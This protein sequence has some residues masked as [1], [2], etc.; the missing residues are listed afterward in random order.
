VIRNDKLS[1]LTKDNDWI[2]ESG[3]IIQLIENKY[4]LEFKDHTKDVPS[5]QADTS[6]SP[7]ALAEPATPLTTAPAN[8]PI[9]DSKEPITDAK[10]TASPVAAVTETLDAPLLVVSGLATKRNKIDFHI[11]TEVDGTLQP[12]DNQSLQDAETEQ[13]AKRRKISDDTSD[14]EG[15][16]DTIMSEGKQEETDDTLVRAVRFYSYRSL[17]ILDRRRRGRACCFISRGR[18]NSKLATRRRS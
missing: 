16:S 6:D 17:Y 2:F 10:E 4:F 3:D 9:T 7:P 14:T 15:K 1:Q 12:T 11:E 8:E 13:E 5:S 18:N